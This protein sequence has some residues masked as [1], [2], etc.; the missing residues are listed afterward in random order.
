[1]QRLVNAR[2]RIL[3]SV[4]R[5][6]SLTTAHS[7]SPS[8]PKAR[9]VLHVQLQKV[10]WG[11]ASPRI[12]VMQSSFQAIRPDYQPLQSCRSSRH[13]C[14]QTGVVTSA[15]TLFYKSSRCTPCRQALRWPT[16]AW[17]GS[18]QLAVRNAHWATFTDFLTALH[19]QCGCQVHNSPPF[20]SLSKKARRPCLE[21]SQRCWV[22]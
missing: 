18:S 15:A 19:F 10:G 21:F 16:S 12:K 2:N 5:N 1:M 13:T 17:Q 22:G 7:A 3:P 11:L 20:G 9:T 6:S 4:P 14:R 8:N